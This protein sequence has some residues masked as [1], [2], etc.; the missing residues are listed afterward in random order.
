MAIQ[1]SH[2]MLI[3]RAQVKQL[4]QREVEEVYALT[5]NGIDYD[6]DFERL[7]DALMARVAELKLGSPAVI[8]DCW[9][10]EEM[11]EAIDTYVEDVIDEA[12][13]YRFPS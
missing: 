12:W 2:D 1:F 11:D 3:L 13:E 10:A 4:I 5:S 9:S 7:L 6:S 8:S